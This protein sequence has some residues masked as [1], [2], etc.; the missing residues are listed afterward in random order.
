[1]RMKWVLAWLAAIV[2][3]ATAHAATASNEWIDASTGHRVLRIASGPGTSLLYFTQEIFT[4]QGDKMVISTADGIAAVDLGSWR[5]TPV[6]NGAG[7]E[8]LFVGRKTRTAY[9][10][11]R[12]KAP[13]AAADA[14]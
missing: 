2:A 11:V 4:P 10:R 5:I 1:M 9:Y 6:V 12:S 8:L 7:L 14:D 13:A 3:A